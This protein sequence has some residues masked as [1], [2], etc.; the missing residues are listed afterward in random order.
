L[1]GLDHDFID[2]SLRHWLVGRL[3]CYTARHPWIGGDGS[4][5]SWIRKIVFAITVLAFCLGGETANAKKVID[6]PEVD[7]QIHPLEEGLFELRQE[8]NKFR[9]AIRNSKIIVWGTGTGWLAVSLAELSRRVRILQALVPLDKFTYFLLADAL[10]VPRD[11]AENATYRR[12]QG[13]VTENLVASW[14]RRQKK[15]GR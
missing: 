2:Q 4:M 3:Y 5:S 10:V 12:D 7:R 9:R 6:R 8:R 13:D 15:S 11:L 14:G 1:G